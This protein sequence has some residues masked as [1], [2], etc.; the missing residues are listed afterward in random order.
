M[1][2]SRE[3]N[4]KF[5]KKRFREKER[6][7]EDRKRKRNKKLIQKSIIHEKTL[8][9]SKI[10]SNDFSLS[11]AR[12]IVT[13]DRTSSFASRFDSRARQLSNELKKV[14][15]RYQVKRMTKLNQSE[16]LIIDEMLRYE[17]DFNTS[18]RFTQIIT[19]FT[20]INAQIQTNMSV[21]THR[22]IFQTSSIV[23]FSAAISKMKNESKKKRKNRK[24]AN[25]ESTNQFSSF[26]ILEVRS[27]NFL[28]FFLLYD[29]LVWFKNLFI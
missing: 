6:A 19:S 20:S 17:Y 12:I 14:R 2:K 26:L 9:S 28:F 15:Q 16:S 21:N 25:D 22:I 11:F 29:S 3:K 8:L 4:Q 23:D 24:T 27:S 7:H 13:S 5:R 10:I 1:T 18:E